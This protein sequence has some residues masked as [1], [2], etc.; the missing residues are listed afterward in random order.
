MMEK[1]DFLLGTWKMEYRVPESEFSAAMTGSGTGTFS[2]ALDDKYVYF[3]YSASFSTG[4]KA[5]AHGIFAWD[6][7]LKIHRYWWF[8]NSGS[9]MMATCRFIDEGVLSMNWHETLLSQ[10]F[11]KTGSDRVVLRMAHPDSAGKPMTVMEVVF[12]KSEK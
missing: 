12:T 3:D 8:E 6:E 2:R 5:E 1:F 11:T 4:D 10:T 9:F 7:K